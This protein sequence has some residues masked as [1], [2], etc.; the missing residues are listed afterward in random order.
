[1]KIKLYFQNN[2]KTKV[3][4][5]FYF[6]FRSEITT[7]NVNL[8]FLLKCIRISTNTKAF[9]FFVLNFKEPKLVIINSKMSKFYRIINL[10]I[11]KIF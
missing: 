2:Y 6:K 5:F 4:Q 8:I 9:R 10:K 1:M 11:F 7:L 3:S